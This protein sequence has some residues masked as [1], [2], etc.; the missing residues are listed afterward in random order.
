VILDRLDQC[1]RYE[2]IHPLFAKAFEILRSTDWINE[3]PGKRA[4]IPDRLLVIV[5]DVDG[6]GRNAAR[7]ESHER[8]LDVQYIVRG[9]ESIGWSHISDAGTPVEVY[10]AGKDIAFFNGVPQAW[11]S[12]PPSH[13][14]VFFREDTHAPLAGD[15]PLRKVIVKVAVAG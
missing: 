8:F 2:T 13:F 10:S 7:L 9:E 4:I 1:S 3:P 11:I 5:E 14:V 12:V 15:G 6:R